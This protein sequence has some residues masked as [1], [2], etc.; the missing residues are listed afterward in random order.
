MLAAFLTA[1]LLAV[2]VT[3]VMNSFSDGETLTA[4]KLNTNFN[5][6][7]AAI[8]SLPNWT[9]SGTTAVYND[10]N[11]T[12]NGRI[13]SSV[14]GVYCGNTSGIGTAGSFISGSTLGA[15]NYG[16]KS[17]S[18]GA[19]SACE[20]ACGNSN[21]H[22]CTSHEISIS[23]QLG[24]TIDAAEQRIDSGIF[25]ID[26]SYY[27]NDCYGWTRSSNTYV[28]MVINHVAGPLWDTVC[29]VAKPLACCL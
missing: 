8:E 12:V 27:G 29:N 24:I 25:I 6:L 1:G 22:M 3:G 7:K 20:T 9:K 10:G 11:V 14:L 15:I 28:S 2:A 26:G 16:G 17:G 23:R 5:T 21:S 4:G 18:P 19:K 13:S